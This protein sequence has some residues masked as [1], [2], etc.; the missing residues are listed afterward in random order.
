VDM[1]HPF[2]DVLA[3]FC[4][5]ALLILDFCHSISFL[6]YLRMGRFGPFRVRALVDVR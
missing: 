4:L 5:S 1:R 6:A 2:K 3:N